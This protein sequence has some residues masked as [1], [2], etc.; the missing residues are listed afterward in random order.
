MMRF[1]RVIDSIN[2]FVGRVF[3]WILAL[4]MLLVSY[5]VFKRYVLTDPTIWVWEVNYHLMCIMGA[6]SGGIALLYKKHINVDILYGKLS[7][8]HKAILDIL[9]CIFFFFMAGALVWYGSLEAI[10]AYVKH[11]RII[12]VLGSPLWPTKS[13]IA[14]GGVLILLQGIAKLIRDIRI[15]AG[16]EGG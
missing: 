2:E 5:E 8:R 13:I 14:I 4:I 7:V 12:S 3:C 9:T 16:K 6:L 11:Q 10:R 1:L 15:V